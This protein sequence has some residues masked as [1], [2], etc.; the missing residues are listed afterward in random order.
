MIEERHRQTETKGSVVA[1]RAASIGQF[2]GLG[3]ADL[4]AVT[5]QQPQLPNKPPTECTQY[6]HIYGIDFSD[7]TSVLAYV[8]SITALDHQEGRFLRATVCVYDM[9]SNRDVRLDVAAGA[10]EL[11]AVSL[12]A[13]GK[14]YPVSSEAWAQLSACS[15]LRALRVMYDLEAAVGSDAQPLVAPPPV[16]AD[17]F[18]HVQSQARFIAALSEIFWLGRFVKLQNHEP[19]GSLLDNPLVTTLTHHFV[20]TSQFRLGEQFFA[21]MSVHEPG[22]VTQVV[23]L[24]AAKEASVDNMRSLL[25]IARHLRT[26]NPANNSTLL[27][28]QSHLLSLEGLHQ[29]AL[30]LARLALHNFYHRDDLRV[31]LAYVHLRAQQPRHALAVL[32][33]LKLASRT[34]SG[35]PAGI[36]S[37]VFDLL[38]LLCRTFGWSNVLLMRSQ[39]FVWNLP[40]ELQLSSRKPHDSLSIPSHDPS[41]Q[42]SAHSHASEPQQQPPDSAR[43]ESPSPPD[44][45]VQSLQEDDL[46]V[47]RRSCADWLDELFS[48]LQADLCIFASQ[49]QQVRAGQVMWT[50]KR[51]YDF[52]VL[53]RRLL[54]EDAATSA[55]QTCL[56]SEKKSIVI[57]ACRAL[58]PLQLKRNNVR[59]VIES[60]RTISNTHVLHEHDD[61]SLVYLAELRAAFLRAILING[62]THVKSE[63]ERNGVEDTHQTTSSLLRFAAEFNT[64]SSRH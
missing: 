29:E 56:L 54:D 30:A 46:D 16:M 50:S 20:A 18:P 24:V 10:L 60:I 37:T 27:K 17:P 34:S 14:Q 47:T 28:L 1:Q 45:V 2:W 11:V 59:G 42:D 4:C 8:H 48:V 40:T 9:L 31:N 62:A 22:L 43:S 26:M 21:E 36:V 44:A 64:D 35:S 53:A 61:M 38:V 49:L 23:T 55:F 12:D 13:E 19:C 39:V 6:H 41:S 58:I 57:K 63:C 15:T 25:L 51:W 32:N 5:L 7:A 52:G 33:T 3:P